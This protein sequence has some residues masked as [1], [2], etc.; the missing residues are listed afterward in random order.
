M[1]IHFLLLFWTCSNIG[2]FYNTFKRKLDVHVNAV[3]SIHHVSSRLS[4]CI[5]TRQRRRISWVKLSPQLPLSSHSLCLSGAL[6]L[7]ERYLQAD[8]HWVTDECCPSLTAWSIP[9]WLMKSNLRWHASYKHHVL[10]P[11]L[12]CLFSNQDYFYIKGTNE[13]KH[14]TK[15]KI[16]MTI[17][18]S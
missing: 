16:V 2:F 17:W 9:I 18:Q 12:F 8:I 5:N 15:L 14:T 10:F 3:I 1:Y 13:E 6:Q 7:P 11:L 4:C